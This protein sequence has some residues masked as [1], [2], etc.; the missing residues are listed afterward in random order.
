MLVALIYVAVKLVIG[1]NGIV[2][3]V[4]VLNALVMYLF[5]GRL[6]KML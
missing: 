2:D 1:D 3:Q 4:D 6:Y 5:L